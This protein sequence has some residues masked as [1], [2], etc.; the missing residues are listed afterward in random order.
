MRIKKRAFTKYILRTFSLEPIIRRL[1]DVVLEIRHDETSEKVLSSRAQKILN[2]LQPLKFEFLPPL[3]RYGSSNE[4][5]YLLLD[6]EPHIYSLVSYGVG[7]DV[8]FEYDLS[9]IVSE[10]VLYDFSVSTLPMQIPNAQFHQIGISSEPTNGFVTVEQTLTNFEITKPLLLKM[11]IE[12]FEWDI[13][14]SLSFEVLH[15]FD[16][17]VIEFHGLCSLVHEYEFQRMFAALSRISQTHLP[18]VIHAN[19]FGDYQIIGNVPIPDVVEVTYA[20]KAKFGLMDIP[21][22]V[23]KKLSYPNNPLRPDIYLSID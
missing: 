7:D 21:V 12:G 3:V 16:Q 11:D 14:N 19:N 10:I 20:R 6:V 8:S 22:K 17:I 1:L 2:L 4:G 9:T 18:V 23:N 15:R 13:L 5:G